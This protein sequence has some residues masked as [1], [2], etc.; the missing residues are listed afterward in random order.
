[1]S[2]GW[3]K[4]HRQIKDHW[5]YNS[6]DPFTK[7]E[8]FFDVLLEVNHSEQTFPIKGELYTCGIGE[9]LNSLETWGKRWRW[10]RSK[11]KRFFTLLEKDSIICL[12]DERKTTRLTLCNWETYQDQRTADEPQTNRKRTAGEPQANTNKN[13]KNKENVKNDKNNILC[14]SFLEHWNSINGIQKRAFRTSSTKSEAYTKI[15]AR[16]K[17]FKNEDVKKFFVSLSESNHI[18]K[19]KWFTLDFCIQSDK[20]FEKVI[21]KW[22]AWKVET[23]QEELPVYRRA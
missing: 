4:L 6:K 20:N 15:K 16:L 23:K 22:M 5:I 3:I 13:E 11:V 14:D 21:N 12:K 8:A 1:M 7:K 18:F 19:E 2:Q 9:C 17:S 10:S